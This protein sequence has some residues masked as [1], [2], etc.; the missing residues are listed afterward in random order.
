MQQ[1]KSGWRRTA[2]LTGSVLVGICGCRQPGQQA[3]P[4]AAEAVVLRLSHITSPGSPWD[5]GARRFAELLRE[6]SDGRLRVEV[7]PGAQLAQH[8]Q[9]AELEQLGVGA[10]PTTMNFGEVFTALQ[11]GTIRA[12]ENPLSIIW[13]SKLY[14]E[15]AERIGPE[16]VR[17]VEAEV[18]Q[19][20]AAAARTAE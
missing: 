17:Q 6:R 1:P 18:S 10:N 3:A 19:A 13:S 4:A 16:L 20:A 2:A 11:Q 7:Y 8:N 14:A 5:L 9:K 15:F 12:Q